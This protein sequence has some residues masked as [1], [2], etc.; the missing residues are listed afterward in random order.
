MDFSEDDTSTTRYLHSTTRYLHWTHNGLST[1][2][3]LHWTHNLR[4]KRLVSEEKKK[5]KIS[6]K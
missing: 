2:R 4:F 1:T 3:Y 6:V 5:P